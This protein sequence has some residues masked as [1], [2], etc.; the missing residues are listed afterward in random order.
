V[1][2]TTANKIKPVL[3]T[4]LLALLF[5]FMGVWVRMMDGSFAPWQQVYLRMFLAG[6]IALVV[7]RRSF[8]VDFLRQIRG[9]DWAMYGLR[10][11]LANTIGVGFFTIAILNADLSTVSFVSS[12]PILGIL[13]WVMFREKLRLAALPFIVISVVGLAMLTG[14]RLDSLQVGWGETAAIIGM[15]GFDIGYMLSRYH[16]KSFSNYQNTTL[17]LL[18][19]WI[20]LFIV[21]MA[22]HEPVIPQHISMSGWIG[23]GMSS[24]L[25]VVGLFLI[26][27]VFGHLKAYVVG[28]LLLL[29]GVFATV[30]GFCLYGEI[31]S[32]MALAGA[33][34]ILGCAYAISAI[35]ARG[36]RLEA[37][38]LEGVS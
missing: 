6:L 32:V 2:K 28:N 34:V 38:Q 27:Y 3:A 12:L 36:D 31:P 35:D 1:T 20:P 7:F 10:G 19:T 30:I 8:S 24:V 25:N 5:V 29:E 14:L 11:F 15:L 26:N 16:P 9:R 18:L 33:A 17:I 22:L 23:L 13:G 21:S 37:A 4:V